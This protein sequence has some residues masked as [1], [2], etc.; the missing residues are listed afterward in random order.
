MVNLEPMGRFRLL[1]PINKSVTY[2]FV[3]CHSHWLRSLTVDQ[4][5]RLDLVGMLYLDQSRII[6]ETVTSKGRTQK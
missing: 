5:Y 6:S 3:Q 1:K 4:I 2:H